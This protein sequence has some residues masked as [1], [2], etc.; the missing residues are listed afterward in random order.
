MLSGSEWALRAALLA[1]ASLLSLLA[2]EGI[3][4]LSGVGRLQTPLKPHPIFH[5]WMP[6]GYEGVEWNYEEGLGEFPVR[7]NQL[8]F[9]MNDE[10]PGPEE[11]CIVFLGD[12]F[13]VARE[14]P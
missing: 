11:P 13:T 5:H 1:G 6:G 3:C 14:V 4:R 12:S 8:G 2:V 10:L 7:F 9:P